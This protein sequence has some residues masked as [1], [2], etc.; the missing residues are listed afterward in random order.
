MAQTQYLSKITAICFSLH[1]V[2]AY[3]GWNQRSHATGSADLIDSL[4]HHCYFVTVMCS[5]DTG[6]GSDYQVGLFN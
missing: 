5:G 3:H 1:M 2:R 6:Y 4:L